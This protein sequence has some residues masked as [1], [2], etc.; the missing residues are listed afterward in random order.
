MEK[1]MKKYKVTITWEG[2][3]EYIEEHESEEQAIEE[4]YDFADGCA[5]CTV[6]AELI[7]EEEDEDNED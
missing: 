3:N 6:T 2:D 4:G 5:S 7:E 1:K